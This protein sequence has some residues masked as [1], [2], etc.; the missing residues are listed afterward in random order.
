MPRLLLAMRV[1]RVLPMVA[2]AAASV[3]VAHLLRH[4]SETTHQASATW[5]AVAGV[6]VALVHEPSKP[7]GNENDACP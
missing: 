4:E 2:V 6:T 5:C 7:D 3:W 1:A